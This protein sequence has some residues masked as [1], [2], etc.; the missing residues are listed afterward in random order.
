MSSEEEDIIDAEGDVE[1][2]REVGLGASS[3]DEIIDYAEAE[4]RIVVTRDTD[5]GQ[6]LRHPEHPGAI[7]LR[8]PFTYTAS[9]I[10]DRLGGFLAKIPDK[11][12]VNAIVIVEL[13]RY[14]RRPIDGG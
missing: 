8:L 7:V 1:D 13:D 14:R 2:V 9:E 11:E 12:L 10:N 5:F 6:V 3:D 4:N